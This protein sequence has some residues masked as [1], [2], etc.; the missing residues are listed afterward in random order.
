MNIQESLH[1][2]L[3]S[4]KVFGEYFY[5][6][7]FTRCPEAKK[8]FA[9]VNIERQAVL[10]TMALVVIEKQRESPYLAAEEYLKYLGTKHH[11]WRI[12]QHLYADW[13]DAMMET[14]AKFH[15]QDW[16]EA[17]SRQW[18]EAIE[19]VIGIMFLGYEQRYTV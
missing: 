17:L 10:L 12:P 8:Y 14:L 13:L 5:E 1:Q 4:K 19:K 16:N 6:T 15:G 3:A 18:R 9:G 2:V 7:F 11:A